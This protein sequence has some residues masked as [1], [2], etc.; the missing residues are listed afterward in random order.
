MTLGLT[1][2]LACLRVDPCLACPPVLTVELFAVIERLL[3]LDCSEMP[4]CACGDKMT[5]RTSESKSDEVIL[6]RFECQTCGRELRLMTWAE[7][8]SHPDAFDNL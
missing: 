1:V 7:N 5:L 3:Q 6:K 8:Q 2:T 4:A